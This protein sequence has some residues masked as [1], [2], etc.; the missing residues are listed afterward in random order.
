MRR[1]LP[2][3][4][5]LRAF[6]AAAR[7]ESFKR[8][9]EELHVTHAA[10][11]RHVRG[12]EE[13]LDCRLFERLHR[14]VVLTP[15]G[16]AYCAI[17]TDA[18]DRMEAGTRRLKTSAGP[19][20]LVVACDSDFAALWLV[21]NLGRFHA[22]HP[23]VAVE[24]KV[25]DAPVRFPHRRTDCAVYYGREDWR[26]MGADLLRN[27]LLSPVCSPRLLEGAPGLTSLA[28]L[29]CHTLL[30]DRTTQEWRLFVDH[31]AIP[32][33]D[34]ESGLIFHR[35]AL[36]LEAAADGQGVA[37]GDTFLTERL[38]GEGRLVRPFP[39]S[40]PAV[41]GYYFL[42][43]E[44]NRELPWVAAFRSWLLEEVC[45]SASE[46]ANQAGGV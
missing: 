29:S 1:D 11:S 4:N 20:R 3:L 10:I 28:D 44:P 37:V 13:R 31:F 25:V 14:G 12:L 32:G 7:H 23:D 21:P 45:T 41:N 18:F 30:H 42:A 6:E 2:S 17:L 39:V 35:S 16:Q 19:R 33:V 22:R 15:A 27:Y 8:A 5:A 34:P 46:H 26:G 43:P 24:V 40:L 38:I 36:A 9:A